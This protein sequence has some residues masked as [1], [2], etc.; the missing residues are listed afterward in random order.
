MKKFSRMIGVTLLEVMLVLAVAA[1]IIVMSIRYYQSA[2]ANQQVN[3]TLSLLQG[4]QAGM[5]SLAGGVRGYD[6]LTLPGDLVK[7]MPGDEIRTP[8]GTE[9]TVT[10]GSATTYTVTLPSMGGTICDMV[11]VRL[12]QDSKW[13]VP[14]C[15]TATQNY[16]FT[17]DSTAS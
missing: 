9:V 17:Y 6:Q 4:I 2:T 7:V 10:A 15:S 1:M 5:D 11:S 13:T 16:Q 8:W 3:G 14:T 12:A